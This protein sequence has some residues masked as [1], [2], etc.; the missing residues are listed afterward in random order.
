MGRHV[1]SWWIFLGL[2]VATGCDPG[3]PVVRDGKSSER[4]ETQIDL[5]DRF[6]VAHSEFDIGRISSLVPKDQRAFTGGWYPVDRESGGRWTQSRAAV[7][8]FTR[9]RREDL[10]LQ[11]HVTPPPAHEQLDAQRLR[12][13][14]NGKN[15][16]S[17]DLEPDVRLVEI[18]V[19]AAVQRLGP[20][21]LTLSPSY[22]V[23]SD[24]G[25]G[26]SKRRSV[27]VR[28]DALVFD[29]GSSKELP[30]GRPARLREGAI[31]QRVDSV[32]TYGLR[33]PAG[34]V[35]RGRASVSEAISEAGVFG[36][37][38]RIILRAGDAERVI[39]NRSL[40]T[41]IGKGESFELGLEEWQG[42]PVH[43]SFL[44]AEEDV[45]DDRASV[46]WHALEITGGESTTGTAFRSIP[47]A[48]YNV[49]IVLFDTLRADHTEP[50]G[51]PAGDTPG[52]SELASRG[53]T[54]ENA[55]AP[56]SWTRSSVASMLTGVRPSVHGTLDRSHSLAE[57]IPLLPEI[58][59][60]ANYS[61]TMVTGNLH[62]GPRF[63]F[64]RGFDTVHESYEGNRKVR[65]DYPTPVERADF[66]WQKYV[67][68][69]L[70]EKTGR[71]FFL[72]LHELDP[73]APY[74]PPS[75][76]SD[77][78]AGEYPGNLDER[79]VVARGY[80]AGIID[81][82]PVDIDHMRGLY[83]GEVSYMDRFLARL[84][85]NL[86]ESELRDDTLVVFVSDHGE[87]FGEHEGLGHGA[88]LFEESIRIPMIWSLPGVL[89]ED[90]RSVQPASLVDVTPTVLD[91][92][93]LGPRGSF[94][95]ASLLGVVSAEEKPDLERNLLSTLK[96]SHDSI[97]SGN[98]K[99]I[100]EGRR[101]DSYTL[102]DLARDPGE[103]L[104]R[105]S[106]NPIEGSV[107][108]QELHWQ[109]LQDQH[110]R[111]SQPPVPTTEDLDPKLEKELRAL[112]YL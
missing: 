68:P 6:D 66:F 43:L 8:D 16:G 31:E 26:A 7:I 89:P 34:A 25:E 18:P 93:D 56:S 53:V 62:L 82:D 104:D 75:P 46:F 76:Y 51:A 74:E 99:L 58:L 45:P 71:P 88:A 67:E 61:T 109:L 11:L 72:Y 49:M 40:E 29:D 107:L 41:L 32:I 101:S 3:I 5:A 30:K 35:L 102:Y 13:Q 33:L 77:Q 48:R 52:I 103:S 78:V 42:Q 86:E 14:W 91:L 92:L 37:R 90:S 112:G 70:P 110:L 36:A 100:R 106:V 15:L 9:S 24:E 105:W 85:E 81:L 108:K 50:Y 95:G 96:K 44:V 4:V 83:A 73:H 59:R 22:T 38:A 69:I 79:H 98:W 54:F 111:D 87:E 64:A 23:W 60:D 12:V 63:G 65:R 2:I 28:L 57:T 17:F 10:K 55:I 21:R 80:R 20:N 19:P 94:Q 97:R 1:H 84:L 27:G 47:R 39:W